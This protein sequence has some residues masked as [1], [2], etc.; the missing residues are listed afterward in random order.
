MNQLTQIE[1]QMSQYRDEIS[2][3]ELQILAKKS[4]LMSLKAQKQRIQSPDLF[5]QMFGESVNVPS[6]YTDTPLAEEYYGG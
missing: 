3:L 2:K 6:I 5:E 4:A 1:K